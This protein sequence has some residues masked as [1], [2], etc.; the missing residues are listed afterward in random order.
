MSFLA[1]SRW[2]LLIALAACLA[3]PSVN[4]DC[5]AGHRAD[6]LMMGH[7]GGSAAMGG[8]SAMPFAGVANPRYANNAWCGGPVTATA[9]TD[10]LYRLSR[11]QMALKAQ[12]AT[13]P[14]QEE[15]SYASDAELMD[16]SPVETERPAWS[17]EYP[18]Q[19]RTAPPVARTPSR[20][21]PTPRLSTG[22]Q[23]VGAFA[24]SNTALRLSLGMGTASYGK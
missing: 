17:P 16:E 19:T 23:G 13:P 8:R 4:A 10:Y 9:P 3:N 2:H 15:T 20:A 12:S 5:C 1:I 18:G 6:Y 21:A 11:Q 7:H 14:E 22:H 24:S